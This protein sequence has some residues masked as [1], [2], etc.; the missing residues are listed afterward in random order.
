MEKK[1]ISRKEAAEVF[2][3]HP[4]TIANWLEKGLLLGHISQR[5]S[6]I[7]IQSIEQLKASF[8]DIVEAEEKI[9]Q[10]KVEIKEQAA[11]YRKQLAAC[12]EAQKQL[13]NDAWIYGSIFR[14]A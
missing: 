14:N 10:Y 9:Q 8:G 3:V 7:D 4:Q 1:Y 13:S 2:G 6:F 5:G 11:E 12:N